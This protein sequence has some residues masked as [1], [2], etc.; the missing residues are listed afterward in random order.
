MLLYGW[1]D[2]VFEK[3]FRGR[4]GRRPVG[5]VANFGLSTQ[6]AALG[7]CLGIGHPRAYLV[8]LCLCT[9]V[10]IALVANQSRRSS[11]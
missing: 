1:Q 10:V 4:P 6:L 5:I 11:T 3:L 2:R 7:V 9:V 8:V